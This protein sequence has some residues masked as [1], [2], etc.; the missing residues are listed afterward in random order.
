MRRVVVTGMGIVSPIGN[1]IDDATDNLRHGRS[2]ITEC[3]EFVEKGFSARSKGSVRNFVMPDVGKDTK[4]QLGLGNALRFG[5]ASTDQAIRDA[6]LT[7]A[8]LFSAGVLFGQGGGSTIDIYDV[9]RRTL[10]KGRPSTSPATVN[11]VTPTMSSGCAAEI[12]THFRCGAFNYAVSAACATG[13][14]AIGLAARHILMGDAP[15]IIAG[16]CDSTDWV[17][18]A[19]FNVL[20]AMSRNPLGL[21]PEQV[22]RPFDKGRSGFVMGEGSGT[23]I[24]EDLDHAK[25]RGA[26]IYCEVLGF[27]FSSDGM[28]E[29]TDPDRNGAMRSMMNAMKAFDGSTIDASRIGYAKAHGTSTEKGDDNELYA[30]HDTCKALGIKV[31]RVGS[32]KSLIGHALGGAGAIESILSILMMNHGFLAP[33]INI[34]NPSDVALELGMEDA[35]L[36]GGDANVDIQAI[37]ANSFGFG[38]T[39]ASLVFARYDG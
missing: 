19:A 17:M 15:I 6:G 24:L 25:A 34:D 13:N 38:G 21:L 14:F 18:S 8:E 11:S 23:M 37:L 4:R 26:K 33:S 32:I 35:L 16:S 1:N 31:P 22:S 2:G 9:A 27:G 7:A 3:L 20:P 30:I 29:P 5:H 36:R 28:G 12:A 10:E 39:N